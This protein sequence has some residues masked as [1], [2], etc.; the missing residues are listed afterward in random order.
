MEIPLSFYIIIPMMNIMGIITFTF[1]GYGTGT[2]APAP[3]IATHCH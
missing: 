3:T 1:I 2:N